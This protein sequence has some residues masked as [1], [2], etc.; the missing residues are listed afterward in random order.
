MALMR[1][2]QLAERSGVPA[3]TLRFYEGAGLLPADRTAAGYR[4]YGEDA[5]DRLR[6]ISTGKHLGL[7]LREIGELLGAWETGSCAE[8]KAALRPRIAARLAEAGQRATVLWAFLASL[9]GALEHLDTLPDRAGHCGQ[10]CGFPA[11]LPAPPQPTEIMLSPG[12]KVA[13]QERE[14]WRTVP[15]TC[16]L[17]G[18]GMADRAAAWRRVLNGAVRAEIPD[19]LRLTLPGSRAA[20]VAGLATAEQ[21]CCPFFDFRLH[22]DGQVLQLEVRAP[23]DGADLLAGLFGPA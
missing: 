17:S 2:S 23:A 12:P 5:L 4:M 14:R 9:Q 8:V 3:T 10:E 21:E 16:S 13:G 11:A 20:A 19:G 6:F 7:S 18:D 22:I 15:V 1:I